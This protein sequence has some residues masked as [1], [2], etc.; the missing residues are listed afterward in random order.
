MLWDALAVYTIQG[1]GACI[2]KLCSGTESTQQG[3]RKMD[4]PRFLAVMEFTAP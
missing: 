4:P 1:L 3:H 2:S